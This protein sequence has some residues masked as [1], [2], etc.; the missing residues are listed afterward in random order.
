MLFFQASNGP[1]AIALLASNPYLDTATQSLTSRVVLAVLLTL[2]QMPPSLISPSTGFYEKLILSIQQTATRLAS[3]TTGTMSQSLPLVI[4]ASFIDRVNT[5]TSLYDLY[6][7]AFTGYSPRSR[8]FD[9][10]S[11]TSNY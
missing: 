6:S 5:F 11:S 9:P 2:P 10:P 7:Q 3:G 4:N 8:N 1:Q